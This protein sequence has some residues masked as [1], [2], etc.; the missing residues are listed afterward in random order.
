MHYAKKKVV[1]FGGGT[2]LPALLSGL[3]DN[4]WLD[5]HAIVST[6]DSGGSSGELRDRFGILPPGD[7]LKCLLALSKHEKVA[8]E[9]LL[10]RITHRTYP[11]HTGGNILLLGFE[12][13]YGD[14]RSAVDALGQLLAI[15]GRVIPVTHKQGT[16]CAAYKDGTVYSGEAQVDIGIKEGKA[17]DRLYLEE[18]VEASEEALEAIKSADAICIGPGSFYTSVIPNFLPTGVAQAL[19]RTSVPVIFTCNFLTEG[20]GMKGYTVEKYVRILEHYIGR[21]VS[22]VV[23]S[24]SVPEE[25]ALKKYAAEQKHLVAADEP[26]PNL[27]YIFADLWT[28]PDIARHDSSKLA[29]LISA[30][31]LK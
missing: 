15:E 30:L 11:G 6:L 22:A 25:A 3:K 19:S 18:E 24:K 9:I 12:K 10:K 23:V 29:S 5:L 27:E 17:V 21:P 4:P 16:I 14:Y 28:D 8:R 26:H 13:V 1:C 2:G 31:I 7:L 20:K